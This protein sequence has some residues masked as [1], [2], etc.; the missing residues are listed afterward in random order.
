ML[1]LLMAIA[2]LLYFRFGTKRSLP[3]IAILP[4]ILLVF[5]GRQSQLSG[6]TAHER[7]MLW[8]EGINALLSRPVLLLTGI[9]A[10]NYAGRILI[11]ALAKSGAQLHTI[12][13]TNGLNSVHFGNKFGFIKASTSVPDLF[14]QK[15]INTVFIATRHDSHAQLASEALRS[16]RHV[17]VEKPLAL[18]REQLCEVQNAYAEALARG[19]SPIIFVGF[20]RRF[21]P[22]VQHMKKLLRA[23]PGPKSLNLLM[24]AGAIPA[25]HWTKDLRIGGGRILGEACHLI[26]LARFLAGTRIVKANGNA[27]RSR[28]CAASDSD[29]AQIS[30]EFEDGSIATI[31][32][33]ANGYRSYPK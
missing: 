23:T 2:T 11:P 26:D 33:Y 20:N 28:G 1:G 31:Q 5:G 32:Y 14:A 25:D 17:Y 4:V 19:A 16:G 21:S 9:G 6:D 13:T 22:H 27:M 12:V 7:L 24:N 10:G 8:A 18:D 29:T 3:L 30:L 15:E